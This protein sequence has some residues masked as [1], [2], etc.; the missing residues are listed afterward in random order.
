[1]TTYTTNLRTE[2]MSQYDNFDFL[3]YGKL[4][5]NVYG[6]TATGLYALG[7]DTDAG[8]QIDCSATTHPHALGAPERNKAA[9]ALYV[10]AGSGTIAVT[11]SCDDIP[12]GTFFGTD[13]VPLARG[14][15]G[16]YWNF[17]LANVGGN[18]LRLQGLEVLA[19]INRKRL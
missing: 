4:G 2:E 3:A 15:T 19:D 5:A 17:T 10:E 1:M 13:R 8:T 9:H 12:V 6:L 16:R 11:P 14:A 7:G 18:D